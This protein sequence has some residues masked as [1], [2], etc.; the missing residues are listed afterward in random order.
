MKTIL[1]SLISDQT[2]PNLQF[3][4]EKQVD[5]YIFLTTKE[6]K[7]KGTLQWLYDASKINID[8]CTSIVVEPYS[9]DNIEAELSKVVNDED[10]YIINLTGGTK[11]MSL[12][13]NDFFK[14]INSEMFYLT[15]TNE[16]IKIFPGRTKPTFA[17][18]TKITLE[19]YL[20]AY[21]FMVKSK[22]IAVKPIDTTIKILNYFLNHIT[23]D[24]YMI[25][26]TLRVNHRGSKLNAIETVS[27]LKELLN[28]FE[29]ECNKPNCLDKYEIKYLTG[30][31]LEEYVYYSVKEKYELTD[32]EIGMGWQI[33]KNQVPNEFDVLFIKNNQLNTIECKSSIYTDIDEKK[34]IIGETIYKSDS[35]KNKFGLFVSTSIL[36]V[37]DLKNVKPNELNRADASM[38]K[39]IGKEAFVNHSIA[40]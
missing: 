3:I 32:D 17:L 33:Q 22:S 4:K 28:R 39:V 16:Y 31:W 6:M 20:T 38:I 13:V 5:E 11:I 30:E 25:L 15:G 26:E 14:D 2:I 40:I 12:A 29:F 36:T 27:G 24:D 34:T 1:V 23:K 19:E 21:G 35:L 9:Y 8:K 18:Q 10:H 37:S 7:H